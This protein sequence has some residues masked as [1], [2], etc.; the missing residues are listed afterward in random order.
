MQVAI[1]DVTVV[2]VVT[3]QL[4]PHSTV[5]FAGARITAVGPTAEMAL[6][7]G[8]EVF[9]GRGLYVIPGL[10]DMHVHA[11]WSPEIP[12]T[13]LP[14]FVALG[15]TGIRDMG[16]RL[17][18]LTTTRDLLRAGDQPWPRVIAAGLV[19]DG[20]QPVEPSISIPVGDASSARAAVDSLARA[21]VDFI[22]VYTLLPGEAFFEVVAAAGRIGLPVAGHV[23]GAVTPEEA[24]RAG[25][26]SIEH[27]RDELE[28]LCSPR[29]VRQCEELAEVLRAERTWLTPTLVPLRMKAYFDD[30][31]LLADERLRYIGPELQ[32]EWRALRESKLS[33]GLAYR[34]EKRQRYSDA[35]WVTRFFADQNV[36]LLAGTDAGVAFSYPGF[37]LHDEL[38]LM[39]EAG[40]SPLAALR[41]ATLGP[42][43][44]LGARDSLGAIAVGHTADL[45]LLRAN[46][47]ADIAATRE[48]EAVVLRG[49]ILD[50]RRI[51]EILNSVAA[52]W[53]GS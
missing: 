14:L 5:V 26:R 37:S 35:L 20:P 27:L 6:P 11:L 2:D 17:D 53:R 12:G 16:G 9:D 15:V 39:V 25:Q 10:W 7:R 8:T 47:L 50:R 29:N 40:V 32:R 22:K 42:A 46:P 48:I 51:N 31:A 49:R 52:V 36:G 38:T 33:R 18:V 28:L 19:V 21:G 43:E 24:A 13:F 4:Q 3:G 34:D 23:P 41:S 44:F 30:P 1:S 45:V